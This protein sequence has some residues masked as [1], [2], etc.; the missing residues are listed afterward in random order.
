MLTVSVADVVRVLQNLIANQNEQQGGEFQVSVR[1]VLVDEE[2]GLLPATAQFPVFD[3]F[4]VV[5]M[6]RLKYDGISILFDGVPTVRFGGRCRFE[7]YEMVE[8]NLGGD[9]IP[10]VSG[11]DDNFL[12]IRPAISLFTENSEQIFL[13]ERVPL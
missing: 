8:S 6:N 4:I 3:S 10:V 1:F 11:L 5:D 2:Y 7:E 12:W 9:G 13:P